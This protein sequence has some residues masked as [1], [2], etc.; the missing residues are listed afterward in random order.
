MHSPEVI[1][2]GFA[3]TPVVAPDDGMYTAM[4]IV[5]EPAGTQRA[6]GML[7]EFPSPQEAR[8]FAFLYGMAEI[9]HRKAPEPD[10]TEKEWHSRKHPRSA[11]LWN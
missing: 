7:G 5:R 6:T 4:L 10:W 2:K 9:D 1:Y 8:R 3:L 11:S